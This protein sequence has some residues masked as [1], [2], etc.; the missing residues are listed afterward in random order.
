MSVKNKIEEKVTVGGGATGKSEVPDPVGGKATLPNSKFDGEKRK[1]G[2]NPANTP[3]EETDSESNVK[4]DGDNAAKNQASIKMKEE[5]ASIFGKDITE[6]SLEEMVTIFEGAVAL[7]VEAIKA[8]IQAHYEATLD[9]E[10]EAIR[11][12]LT[13]KVDDH[14]KYTATKWLE[15]NKIAVESTLKSELTEDFIDGLKTLFA[16]HYMEIPSDKIDVLENLSAKVVELESKLDESVKDTIAQT[17]IIEAF[18]RS[19]TLDELS[20]G[21]SL[22]QKEKLKT[23]AESLETIELGTYKGKLETL[24]ESIVSGQ[25]KKVDS[26]VLTETYENDEKA[27]K[28]TDPRM[29][30]Y[31]DQISRSAKSSV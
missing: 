23:M 25:Y 29:A 18:K 8:E 13:E 12:A 3:V 7:K 5:L 11:D 24:K 20:T 16:N 4:A 22:A 21:L 15:E 9:E 14:L 26:N 31:V 6:E 19:E 27:A 10:V 2:Q 17:K 28:P 30:R 1:A